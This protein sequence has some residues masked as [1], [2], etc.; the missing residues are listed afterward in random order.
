MLSQEQNEKLHHWG[1]V[2]GQLALLKQTEMELRK[3]CALFALVE[4][5]PEAFKEQIDIGNGYKLK[6][7]NVINYKLDSVERV[8]Q[9]CDELMKAGFTEIPAKVFKWKPELSLSFY[10]TLT[11]AQKAIV[12]QVVS[13]S[14]GSPKLEIVE[15]KKK[16]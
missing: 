6:A 4:Y 9:I 10:K 15:P 12:D 11:P 3:E 7:E 16:V 8:E 1:I 13:T 5:K 14:I 2:A